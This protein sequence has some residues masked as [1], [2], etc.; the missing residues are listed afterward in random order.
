[1]LKHFSYWMF[2]VVTILGIIAGHLILTYLSQFHTTTINKSWKTNLNIDTKEE[3]IIEK[4][5]RT[6]VGV[7]ALPN[8]EITYFMASKDLLGKSLDAE[9]DYV[10]EGI[11]PSS[12]IW[13]VTLYDENYHLV[14]N[15]L[16]KYHVN[17]T[18]LNVN[19]GEPYRFTIS[20][21][22]KAGHWLPSPRNGHF[23]LCYR[24]YMPLAEELHAQSVQL[25]KI[26]K[27]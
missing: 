18:T 8:K 9:N 15:T 7:Y 14:P 12:P 11:A 21:K 19:K 16:E 5:I 24:V 4:A 2:L 20:H 3:S 17:G 23:I 22:T 13:S 27:L 25:P 1:M 10:V 6:K 26:T